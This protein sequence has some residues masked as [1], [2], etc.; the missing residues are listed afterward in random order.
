MDGGALLRFTALFGSISSAAA[1]AAL[2]ALEATKVYRKEAI[3]P[4]MRETMK[5]VNPQ[6]I[7]D[8]LSLMGA[9]AAGLVLGLTLAAIW[10][11][12]FRDRAT[13]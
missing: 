9:V 8:G 3:F 4:W 7:G 10:L 13:A 12:R 1:I 6:T 2:S 5:I 11:T